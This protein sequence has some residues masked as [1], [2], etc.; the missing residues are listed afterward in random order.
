MVIH[1]IDYVLVEDV[2]FS[3]AFIPLHDHF[4]TKSLAID[5]PEMGQHVRQ[6]V[7]EINRN[8]PVGNIYHETMDI[9][10]AEIIGKRLCREIENRYTEEPNG[11]EFVTT[12]LFSCLIPIVG[13][14]VL[15]RTGHTDLTDAFWFKHNSIL[16]SSTHL[17]YQELSLYYYFFRDIIPT[18]VQQELYV[19]KPGTA[20]MRLPR[21]TGHGREALDSRGF[22]YTHND[23]ALEML[24]VRHLTRLSVNFLGH[25]EK[26]AA[27]LMEVSIFRQMI[28]YMTGASRNLGLKG[29][30]REANDCGEIQTP[31][32]QYDRNSCQWRTVSRMLHVMREVGFF[33]TTHLGL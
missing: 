6:H 31:L 2:T 10:T 26:S 16:H 8:I 28:R 30:E 27:E 22:A 13:F 17:K 4:T 7:A 21:F 1:L 15:S 23:E 24:I 18:F 19:N 3:E 32:S 12:V 33:S 9:V 25:L 20:V 5:S 14:H 11:K 29:R